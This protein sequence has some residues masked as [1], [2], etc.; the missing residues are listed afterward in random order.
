MKNREAVTD[1]SPGLQP[2]ASRGETD[3]KDFLSVFKGKSDWLGRLE[4]EDPRAVLELVAV[5]ELGVVW[6]TVE[7][8]SV[9]NF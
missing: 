4:F 9:D 6:G 3:L 2:W 1:H 5:M 8:H 7:P